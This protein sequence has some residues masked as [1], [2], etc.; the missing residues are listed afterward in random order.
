MGESKDRERLD[1][2]LVRNKIVSSRERAK[3]MIL[4]GQILL[5]GCPAV[6]PSALID[7]ESPPHVRVIGDILKYVSRGGLKMEKALECFP[8]NVKDKVCLDGGASSGG[9]TDCMLMNGAEKVFAVDVGRG[10]LDGKLLADQRVI[11]MEGTNLRDLT[12]D[13]LGEKVDL[14]SVDVS[15]I[16]LTKVL[17]P[18]KSCLKP[19]GQMVCLIKP[20]F[21]AG[22]NRVGKK[23][24][25]K[26]SGVRKEVIK[27]V[28]A[29]ARSI[30]LCAE[31]LTYSPVRGPEGNIEFLLYLTYDTESSDLPGRVGDEEI[32][33]ITKEAE[34]ALSSGK[35]S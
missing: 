10:Q 30:G 16:S 34:Q 27:N 15:F 24:V 13:M 19:G 23:G 2:Y 33:R 29:F 18:L 14:I 32:S 17:L 3:E 25:V 8:V 4:A 12:P 28:I 20:Q 7:P 5:D 22:K 35:K 6:K 9:F 1:R 26:D 21:E 11:S 31:G